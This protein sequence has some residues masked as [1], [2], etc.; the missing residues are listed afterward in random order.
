MS[1]AEN[2]AEIQTRI[3]AACD[4][5]GRSMNTVKLIAVSKTWPAEHVQQAVISGQRIFGENR[6]Q[7]GQEK[8]PV[9]SNELEWHFIGGLQK[10]KVRKV[11]GLFHVVH[12]ID[13]LK[14]ALYTNN[15]AKD[16][17]L[18]PQ[19]LLQVNIGS[20]ASKGGFLA[21]ELIEQF[22]DMLECDQLQICGLMCIPPAVALPEE[23]RVWFVKVRELKELLE[24]KYKVNLPHLSMGMSGDFEVAIEEGATYVRVGTSIFGTR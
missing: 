17:R 6:L 11:L 22:P 2:L 18:K 1:V 10:N 20:E 24:E 14:L 5:V 3:T 13:S 23:A 12:S 19:V 4:R 9:M 15:V 8:I 16:L 7:E 21:K